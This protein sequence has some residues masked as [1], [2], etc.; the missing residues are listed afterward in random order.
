MASA[1]AF[2]GDILANKLTATGQTTIASATITSATITNATIA[3]SPAAGNDVV[4]KAYVDAV[5]MG[6]D[7]KDSVRTASTG[8]LSGTYDSATKTLTGLMEVLQMDGIT[9][10]QGDRVL[11]KNQT[12]AS[13]NGIFALTT[14]GDESTEWVLTRAEDFDATEKITGGAFVFVYDGSASKNNGYI[15]NTLP[16]DFLLDDPADGI[17]NFVQFSGVSSMSAGAGL[18]ANN[19]AYDVV[20]TSDRI[21]VNADSID[22][23]PTYAGQTSIE[24]VGALDNGSISGAADSAFVL[25]SMKMGADTT[26]A[27]VDLTKVIHIRTSGETG[28][29]TINIP[30]AVSADE[31]RIHVFTN[32]AHSGTGTITFDFNTVAGAKIQAANGAM[33]DQMV[34]ERGQ[35]MPMFYAGLINAVPTWKQIYTGCRFE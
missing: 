2:S 30:V 5:A 35:S 26:G 8:N 7:V 14:V 9:L 12:N 31:D 25:N 11:L 6:R 1:Y 34:L 15:I 32:N 23:A 18:I 28:N 27:T 29:T 16:A 19:G 17:L 10:V 33:V 24:T 22:I 13:E 20:G 21:I 3:G 4:N